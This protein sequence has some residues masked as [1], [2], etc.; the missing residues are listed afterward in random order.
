[1]ASKKVY[2]PIKG[3]TC[4]SCARTIEK[5]LKKKKGVH[6]ANVNFASEKAYVDL[7]PQIINHN[8]LIE[9]VREFGYDVVQKSERIT[10]EIGGMSCASC[11]Q[12]IE[13]ALK[14]PWACRRL[15]LI[16]LPRR[17]LS[18]MINLWLPVSPCQY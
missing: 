9:A 1:M 18:P 14:K 6:S 16:L 13:K 5:N 10:L 3:M 7:D 11:A 2:L 8:D 12:R 17:H 4:T 15:T